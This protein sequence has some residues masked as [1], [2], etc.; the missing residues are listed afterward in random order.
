MLFAGTFHGTGC[1]VLEIFPGERR[2]ERKEMFLWKRVVVTGE[3]KKLVD[4]SGKYE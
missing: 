4:I 3:L 2:I 1:V